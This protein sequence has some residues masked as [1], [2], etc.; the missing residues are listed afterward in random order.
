MFA[1]FLKV[2]KEKQLKSAMSSAKRSNL[3]LGS[4]INEN[5][6]RE[7]LDGL[8]P[9]ACTLIVVPPTLVQHWEVSIWKN[10]LA[11]CAYFFSDHLTPFTI[12]TQD[13][14]KEHIDISACSS[15]K[16]PLI[17][18]HR[19]GKKHRR[20]YPYRETSDFNV[21]DELC[22]Q[23]CSHFPF[24][25]IDECNEK[26]PSEECISSFCI[27]LTTTKVCSFSCFILYSG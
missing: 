2:F 4:L 17:Y 19:V 22:N 27:V 3:S 14:I 25:F 16:I 1:A 24:L 15:V 7:L 21:Y 11:S 9:S 8:I 5:K 12:K 20:E 6:M 10:C 13:Q 18:R 26:L 23:K